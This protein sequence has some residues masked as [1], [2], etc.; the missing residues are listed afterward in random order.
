VA[1][2]FNEAPGRNVSTAGP[3]PDPPPKSFLI[4]T[5]SAYE[6]GCADGIKAI[7]YY[8]RAYR[9]SREAMWQPGPVPR[10]W[11]HDCDVVRR[12]AVAWREKAEVARTELTEWRVYQYRWQDWM[13]DGWVRIGI[14]ESGHNPPNWQ[15]D[16]GSYQGA[17]G[18]APSS[19]DGFKGAADADA[20]PYPEDANQATPRQQYEVALAIYRRYGLTGWGCRGH[21][22]G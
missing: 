2:A 16:S 15:H 7:T 6:P 9:A 12:R 21:Y 18:F 5:S 1:A 4:A 10:V 13:P 22:Y 19:W 14:C 17:F 8:R 11:Y 20:G 3:T